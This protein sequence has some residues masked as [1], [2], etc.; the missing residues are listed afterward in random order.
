[1]VSK[2]KISEFAKDLEKTSKE[3]SQLLKYKF[4]D[5]LKRVT[6]LTQDKI[7]FVLDFYSQ[8]DQVENFD[9]YFSV[10][11]VNS[12]SEED[13]G[14]II[15]SY[16]SK[17]GEN[18]KESKLSKPLPKQK[19]SGETKLIQESEINTD[20]KNTKVINTK[21]ES[22]NIDKYNERYDA[23]ANSKNIVKSDIFSSKQKIKRKINQYRKISKKKETENERL[24]RIERERKLKPL[25]ISMPEKITVGEFAVKLK[26]KVSEVTKKLTQLGITLTADDFLDFDSASLIALEFH[27]KVTKEIQKSIEEMVINYEEDKKEDLKPRPPVVVIMGHVDHGKTSLLDYIRK[28]KV[29]D[30]EYGGITQHIGAYKI[31]F[32]NSQITFL[33][34]PGHEAFTA[35]RARGASITDIAIL[36]VAADDGVKPQTIEAI[37][38]AKEAEVSI[39]IAINKI[40]K[41]GADI[42]KIKQQLGEHGIVPEAWGG[43]VP[44][45][46]VSAKTGQGIDELLEMIIL[47]SELKDL[48]ANPNRE[49][50]GTVIESRLDKGSGP[51]ATLLV[52]NGTLKKS[53]IIVI[54][55]TLG[56]IRTIK[57]D[58]NKWLEKAYPSDPVEITGLSDVP[59]SGDKFN[60]VQNERLARQLVEQKKYLENCKRLNLDKKDKDDNIFESTI[61]KEELKLKIILKA[62]VQG[63]LEAIKQSI[64]KIKLDKNL[65]VKVVHDAIG[66]IKESDVMFAKA[67]EAI[68]IGFNVRPAE[69]AEE[70]AKNSNVTIKLYQIIYDCINDINDLLDGLVKPKFE[71]IEIG[72]AECRRVYKVTGIGVVAGCCVISG[73]IE[74]S[75]KVQILRDDVVV[76]TDKIE[77]L[78]RFKDDVKEAI[79][80]YECGIKLA[81]F[82]DVK[83]N[84]KIRAYRVEEVSRA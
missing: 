45:V 24:A 34:T 15:A 73:K 33:D 62:D 36:V 31:N 83:L 80:G 11:K 75:A 1:M 78:K 35:L 56:K 30:R 23:I 47:V 19:I 44:F 14:T 79:C 40:D 37:N 43:D 32:K 81:Y 70:L 10:R 64:N 9:D 67:S 22:V 6:I 72:I 25:K 17:V 51:I 71:E 55:S 28:T 26:A 57:S 20:D 2:Y 76:F 29:A 7:N 46:G 18:V 48:R 77:S 82:S 74:R 59:S 8:Q 38:H 60:V 16:K 41:A 61:K 21:D 5:E 27:A 52:A 49:A 58:D 13:I 54:G 53:D 65:E 84:D 69:R 4:N 50:N 42:D 3:I 66:A 12:V 63:S 68:I 39:I